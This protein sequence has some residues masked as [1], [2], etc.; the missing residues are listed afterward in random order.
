MNHKLDHI[1]T[2]AL[3]ACTACASP[4]ESWY[5]QVDVWETSREEVTV[6][7]DLRPI[8]EQSELEDLILNALAGNP[9]L[10]ASFDRWEAALQR[11]PQAQSLPAPRLTF[12]SYL[13]DVETRVGPMQGRIGLAQP[14]PWFG[15]RAA[16]ASA[17]E[18]LASA[19]GREVEAQRLEVVHR[20][21]DTWYELGWLARAVGITERHK[22]LLLGWEEVA[23]SHFESGRGTFADVIRAQVELGTLENRVQTLRDLQR[24]TAAR[25]NAALG[26]L[27]DA[28]LPAPP[29]SLPSAHPVNGA[30]L[31]AGLVETSPNLLAQRHRIEAAEQSLVLAE[32]AFWPDFSIG[33]D[34]TFIGSADNPAVSGSGDDAF[35]VSLGI[36]LPIWR[37][38]YRAGER[39]AQAQLAGAHRM[40]ESETLELS[41][42][43]EL[44]LFELRDAGRRIEL[45]RNTLIPKG[46]ESVAS[47]DAGY[48]TG[49]Q[50]FLDLLDA[51]RVLLEFQLQTV[52]AEAD[53]A[54]ALAKIERLSG[55]RTEGNESR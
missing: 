2:A 24:P 28:P 11:V 9:G 25:L 46:E 20:V 47:I 17:A 38:S 14:F 55:V 1:L 6:P 29:T 52:R 18:H 48:R 37:S 23:R 50:G 15:K 34:Y 39:E 19:A 10:Q 12:A 42:S 7:P 21:R 53:S 44:A 35:A 40:L 4:R 16:A 13:A 27:P 31:S 22:I 26:R 45:F 49:D 33:A 43:L 5:A 3:V 51:E 32:K 8:D 36:E 54:Q 30:A 41:S